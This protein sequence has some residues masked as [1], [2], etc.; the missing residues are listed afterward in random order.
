MRRS[1]PCP[2][3]SPP[4]FRPSRPSRL[5]RLSRLSPPCS[6]PVRARESR[7]PPRRGPLTT[8]HAANAYPPPIHVKTWGRPHDDP[9]FRGLCVNCAR[10][11]ARKLS[12]FA[13]PLP[14]CSERIRDVIPTAH[15]LDAEALF[16]RLASDRHCDEVVAGRRRRDVRAA[17]AEGKPTTAA[18]S[19]ASTTGR[20]WNADQQP[21]LLDRARRLRTRAPPATAAPP[22][23]PGR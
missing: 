1:P 21:D 10:Y 5:S 8:A 3:S 22:P 18:A 14:P 15:T 16:D 4:S 6:C 11:N 19:T 23:A 12:S 17:A 20:L 9:T 7:T 2:L 13:V